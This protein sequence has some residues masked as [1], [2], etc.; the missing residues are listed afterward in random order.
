MEVVR[1]LGLR[2]LAAAG[3]SGAAVSFV[4]EDQIEVAV[5][6]HF[7]AAELAEPQQSIAAPSIAELWLAEAPRQRNLLKLHD[8]GENRFRNVAECGGGRFDRLLAENVPHA[9]AQ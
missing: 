3:R 7:T 2:R 9:H 5:I 8:L 6:A 4:D 1:G